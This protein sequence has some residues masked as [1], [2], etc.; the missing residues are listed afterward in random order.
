MFII[1]QSILIKNK[2]KFSTK[3]VLFFMCFF[4]FFLDSVANINIFM[5]NN[6]NEFL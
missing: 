3:I 4:F 2:I 5:Y 6:N 1:N